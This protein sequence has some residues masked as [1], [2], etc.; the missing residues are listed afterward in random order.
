MMRRVCVV[1]EEESTAF[2]NV[3]ALYFI[4]AVIDKLFIT[5]MM[6]VIERRIGLLNA[7]VVDGIIHV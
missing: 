1:E 5:R 3:Y 4:Y 6:D 2:G 7:N